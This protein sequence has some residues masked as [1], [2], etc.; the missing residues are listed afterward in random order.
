MKSLLRL[1]AAFI[2]ALTALGA[3]GARADISTIW[4]NNADFGNPIINEYDINTGAVLYQLTTPLGNNGRGIVQIGDILYYTSANTNG[5]YAYN[6]VTNTNLGT[7]FTVA[8]SS[9][10]S[11]IAYDGTNFWIGDYSGTNHAYLYTPTGTLLKTISLGNCSGFCDGLEYFNGKLISNRSDEPFQGVYDV[12]DLDGNLITSAFLKGHSISGTTGIAFDGTFFYTDEIDQCAIDKFDIN[13]NYV[14]T[15]KL[16]GAAYCLGEDLSVN[17]AARTDTGGGGGTSVP[18]PG[19]LAL[20]GAGLVGF[21]A[22]RRRWS[23]V[24]SSLA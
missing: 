13:G 7:L 14:S 24:S 12:Y 11:T 9:G 1:G 4:V 6:F 3:G 5:V 15:T 18:E 23:R 21:A 8:G 17:Y 10:L 19:T 20:F 16:T 2:F 22:I